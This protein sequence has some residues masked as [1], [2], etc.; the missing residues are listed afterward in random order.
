MRY[1]IA[2]PLREALDNDPQVAGKARH[3]AGQDATVDKLATALKEMDAP[4][5]MIVT[6]RVRADGS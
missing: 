5:A 3:L 6:N 1:L 2:E 4:P